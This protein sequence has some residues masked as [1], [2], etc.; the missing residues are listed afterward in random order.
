VRRMIGLMPVLVLTQLIGCTTGQDTPDPAYAAM[1]YQEILNIT[2][3]HTRIA[4]EMALFL[5]VDVPTTP[6]SVAELSNRLDKVWILP[7]LFEVT[8]FDGI[9]VKDLDALSEAG[10][11]LEVMGVSFQALESQVLLNTMMVPS[12]SNWDASPG[13]VVIHFARQPSAVA[14]DLRPDGDARVMRY[15]AGV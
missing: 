7:V 14:K 13:E 11:V 5:G 4:E 12:I 10:P 9:T 3:E 6:A 15:G 2:D 8:F 1:R